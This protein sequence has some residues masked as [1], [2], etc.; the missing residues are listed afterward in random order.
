MWDDRLMTL[1]SLIYTEIPGQVQ[2]RSPASYSRLQAIEMI[3]AQ[4]VKFHERG[5]LAGGEGQCLEARLDWLYTTLEGGITDSLPMRIS[6]APSIIQLLDGNMFLNFLSELPDLGAIT[7]S[8][9]YIGSLLHRFCIC[10]TGL[11][12]TTLVLRSGTGTI[13]L[14]DTRTASLHFRTFRLSRW[15]QDV[16]RIV[17]AG[18]VRSARDLRERIVRRLARRP[19]A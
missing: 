7:A 13:A 16:Q 4:L 6:Y 17:D 15:M 14:P 9:R 5:G 11:N 1:W 8:P 19:R 3:E 18:D 10:W 2:G 12:P